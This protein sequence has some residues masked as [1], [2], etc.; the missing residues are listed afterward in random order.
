MYAKNLGFVSILKS[1]NSMIPCKTWEL[2]FKYEKLPEPSKSSDVSANIKSPLFKRQFLRFLNILL[3]QISC[4]Y[5]RLNSN[6]NLLNAPH[7]N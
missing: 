7:H 6:S 4:H 1:N 5:F 3:T 2:L